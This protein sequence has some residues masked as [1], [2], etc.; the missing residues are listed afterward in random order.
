MGAKGRGLPSSVGAG[1]LVLV[2]G[3]LGAGAALL[4]GR[5]PSIVRTAPEGLVFSLPRAIWAV[6]FLGPLLVGFTAYVIRW[7][8]TSPSSAPLRLGVSVAVAALVTALLLGM[9]LDTNWNGSSTVSIGSTAPGPGINGSG[10]HGNNSSSGHWGTGNGTVNGTGTS[11][12]TGHPNGTSN[13]SSGSGSGNSSG[14]NGTKGG[15]SHGGGDGSG[16]N[17]TGFP[18]GAAPAGGVSFGV[19]N[20]AFLLL[21]VGLSAVVGVLAVPGVLAR[22]VDRRSRAVA[23][24]A[25]PGPRE[26]QSALQEAVVA[27]ENGET[28][29]DSIVRLYGRLVGRVAPNPDG[30][31]TST[32]EEIQRTWLTTLHVPPARSQELTQMFEEACYSVHPIGPQE[33]DRFVETMRAIERDL[34]VAG[35]PG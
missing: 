10:P 17:S 23:L 34:F 26:V 19:S 30:L 27:I 11:N 3:L 31:T 16:N 21:A 2:F 28:P 9:L 35:A 13:N 7:A 14:N 15:G 5:A 29:R 8:V 25:P 18:R 6:L 1:A 33:A 22:L 12:G 20:W 32:A 4:A 24:P